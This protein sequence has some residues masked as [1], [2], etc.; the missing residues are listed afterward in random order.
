MIRGL[1]DPLVGPERLEPLE[2]REIQDLLVQPVAQEVRALQALRGL[3]AL[4]E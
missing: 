3:R 1:P 2:K 4:L